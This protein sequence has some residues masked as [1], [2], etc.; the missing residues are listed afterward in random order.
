MNKYVVILT[1]NG[2]ETIVGRYNT[3]EAAKT[4]LENVTFYPPNCRFESGLHLDNDGMSGNGQDE[5][6]TFFYEIKEEVV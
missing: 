5:D 1:E 6:G 3:L 4:Y 2:E